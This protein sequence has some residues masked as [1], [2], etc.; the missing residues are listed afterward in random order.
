[1]RQKQK[2]MVQ[3]IL[4]SEKFLKWN[5]SEILGAPKTT[6]RQKRKQK[7][8]DKTTRIVYNDNNNELYIKVHKTKRNMK[9]CRRR[10]MFSLP[11]FISVS[12][13]LLSSPSFIS[14]AL[15]ISVSLLLYRFL[16]LSRLWHLII[17]AYYSS[18]PPAATPA[19]LQVPTTNNNKHESYSR[20]HSTLIFPLLTLPFLLHT[21]GSSENK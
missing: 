12:V 3:R 9:R 4:T 5:S 17:D 13:C 21:L 20:V 15:S 19:V 11:H 18:M 10:R 8:Q 16:C 7:T 1:M 2:K 14:L 6:K